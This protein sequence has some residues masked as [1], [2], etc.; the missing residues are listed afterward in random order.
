M[1]MALKPINFFTLTGMLAICLLQGCASLPNT[2]PL[3]SNLEDEV[4]MPGFHDIRAWGDMRSKALEQSARDSIKQEL[5]SNHGKLK[6]EV[7]ALA[8]SGGGQDGAFGAGLL[9][10]WTKAGTRPTFKLVTGISTGAL[11]APFAFLGP[12]YDDKLKY[13]YTNTSDKDI[14]KPYSIFTLL[15]AAARITSV[16][17][18]ADNQPLAKLLD[19]IIDERMLKEIAAE[20]LKGRRLLIGTSEM[21]SQRLVIWDMGAIAASNS[22]KA[23]P[24]FRKI[25]LASSA[26]PASFPP[27]FFKVVAEGKQYDEMHVDGGVEVQVMLFENA[28]VPFSREGN[29]LKGQRRI[30]RLYIIRNQSVHPKWENVKPQLKF[31]AIRSIDSLIKS[32]SIGD[33][34]RLYTYAKRDNFEYN[35]AYVPKNFH[36]KPNGMFDPVYMHQLFNR[37]YQLGQTGYPWEH[38]PYGFNPNP[39]LM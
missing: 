23:L 7:D 10:G 36:E 4:Q 14:Y 22:P 21:Y 3:P 34:Y 8:L 33:L 18:L 11:M 30:R 29:F 31:I 19:K 1:L 12:S 13:F 2:R 5:A 27:Q 20:H 24:L 35:L 38:H 37:G 16:P 32:Q 39:I 17:S 6:P 15:L 25:I 28:I 9:C 26:L